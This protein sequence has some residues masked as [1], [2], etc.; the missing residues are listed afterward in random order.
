MP[1]LRYDNK[2]FR[3]GAQGATVEAADTSSSYQQSWRRSVNFDCYTSG[4]AVKRRGAKYVATL[5]DGIRVVPY[6]P[7]LDSSF[8]LVFRTSAINTYNSSGLAVGTPVPHGYSEEEIRKIQFAQNQNFLVLA[9]SSHPVKI[10]L[11]NESGDFELID[12]DFIA[13]ATLDENK[14]VNIKISSNV[15]AIN[16]TAIL[17][18]NTSLFNEDMVG[19]IWAI[20]EA[21]GSIGRYTEWAAGGAVNVGDYRRQGDNVYQV[22]A[23]SGNNTTTNIPPTHDR[24]GEEISDGRITF[25]F[26]NKGIGYIK[27]TQFNSSTSVTGLVQVALPPSASNVGSAAIPTARWNEGSYSKFRGFPSTVSFFG[28]RSVFGK[29]NRIDGSVVGDIFNFNT[30]AGTDTDSL[31]LELSSDRSA[32]ISW[33][34]STDRL[35]VGT[36][37]GVYPIETITPAGFT[38]RRNIADITSDEVKAVYLNSR[39]LYMDFSRNVLKTAIFFDVQDS[40][41]SQALS[42]DIEEYLFDVREMSAGQGAY[43]KI[44]MLRGDGA[45]AIQQFDQAR[46]TLGFYE[47]VFDCGEVESSAVIQDRISEKVVVLFE[48]GGIGIVGDPKA[49]YL[50]LWQEIDGSEVSTPYIGKSVFL[51]S[52]KDDSDFAIEKFV[53]N[54]QI[55]VRIP[56]IPEGFTEYVGLPYTAFGNPHR[57]SISGGGQKLGFPVFQ[58]QQKVIYLNLENTQ[59]LKVNGSD[60][61]NR[62]ASY[63]MDE[64]P[65]AETGIYEAS[66]NIDISKQIVLSS[67]LPLSCSLLS[68]SLTYESI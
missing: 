57:P 18:A 32:K 9:V 68:Y 5:T 11:R 46:E 42:I 48:D 29:N 56:V 58:G 31:S 63:A 53:E 54:Y 3:M 36:Q 47:W 14:N 20:T 60:V 25:L 4:R 55:S 21:D 7:D 45:L 39:I 51:V 37:A 6:Q 59:E 10:F 22:V 16:S 61:I 67:E 52:C 41:I 64:P 26:L 40:Y 12:Y 49:P 65:P 33:I 35:V 34:V 62:A 24:P 43:N 44:Y 13:G 8:F 2:G 66:L 23:R 38:G 1:T 27:L 30:G 17:T 15:Y 19:G 28:G 50:D